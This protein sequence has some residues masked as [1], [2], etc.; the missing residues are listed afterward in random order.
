MV[1]VTA[2][3]SVEVVSSPEYSMFK[4]FT[5]MLDAAPSISWFMNFF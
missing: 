5:E 1:G 2:V 4:I 3:V